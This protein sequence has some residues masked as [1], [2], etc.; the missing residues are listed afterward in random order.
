MNR[1][2]VVLK[3]PSSD[4]E[5]DVRD[6]KEQ[7]KAL[8]DRINHPVLIKTTQEEV[9]ESLRLIDDLKFFLT[10]APVNWQENQIIRRYYLNNELGF[11]S[12][13]FWNN[14][15][16]ITGTD[17]VK[18]AL[19]RMQK[20]G[21]T[22]IQKKKF[23]EGIF[24]DLRNLKCGIDATLE[25]P[26]SE[27]LSFL[28]K[29]ICLKTQKKQKVFFWFSVPHDKL[30]AD[31]LERDLK[32]EST[33]QQST[34][35]AVN[36]P[37]ISFHY[38]SESVKSL[39]EQLIEYTNS[40]RSNT[41][42]GINQILKAPPMHTRGMGTM[43]SL[44]ARVP[45]MQ[46]QIGNEKRPRK[47]N[48]NFPV[49]PPLVLVDN[50]NIKIDSDVQTIPEPI[51][52]VTNEVETD[53]LL[54][55]APQTLVL[56]QNPLLTSEEHNHIP[57]N[58]DKNTQNMD[59]ED[60]PLDYF[61]ISIEY[62]N[63]DVEIFDPF[64]I[65]PPLPPTQQLRPPPTAMSMNVPHSATTALYDIGPPPS[66]RND[67]EFMFPTTATMSRFPYAINPM[68]LGTPSSMAYSAAINGGAYPVPM[69]NGEYYA[70]Q[71]MYDET[72]VPPQELLVSSSFNTEED[73]KDPSKSATN[74]YGMPMYAPPPPPPPMSAQGYMN[75][76]RQPPHPPQPPMPYGNGMPEYTGPYYDP[77]TYDNN[78]NHSNT[79][80]NDEF[81]PPT[82]TTHE[83]Y[84]GNVPTNHNNMTKI[85]SPMDNTQLGFISTQAMQ[86]PRST[87]TPTFL[88]SRPFSPSYR[89]A[90]NTTTPK[91]SRF[92]PYGMKK[93]PMHLNPPPYGYKRMNPESPSTTSGKIKKPLHIKT[94]SYQ[95]QY[96]LNM[97][98][99][100][101][102]TIL[103]DKDREGDREEQDQDQDQEQED[104][105]AHDDDDDD[106]D[107]E[108]NDAM[109]S[110]HKALEG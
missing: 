109:E 80:N 19:Y 25:Q 93:F 10:T 81:Y 34:T 53:S 23:E 26:K 86:P 51:N 84:Y 66:A 11:V 79:N 48:H 40:H 7:V 12:C 9:E 35:K 107:D 64:G 105:G 96:K 73:E 108:D 4:D 87:T 63:Q 17:I 16:Y 37:A 75:S 20:F 98:S 15:Y 33:N 95:K 65:P 71:N 6:D 13:V 24:S 8:R 60:F 92:S 45:S 36:D 97:L 94:S 61:P 106:D 42:G 102:S 67:E 27:F 88:R 74:Q 104:T 101:H 69:T 29:N 90:V 62:P 30:F 50:N 83:N 39:Y 47:K 78:N 70:S 2:E 72:G 68:Q 100:Q 89:S 57:N 43:P 21:R 28:F 54:D 103:E 31:A 3:P 91:S 18:C 49:P 41:G 38:D 56:D 82:N 22:I 59:E 5:L 76:Y 32:R 55:Y 85:F 46:Q 58:T 44:G 1:T 52:M 14:L 77:I 110:F 99:R